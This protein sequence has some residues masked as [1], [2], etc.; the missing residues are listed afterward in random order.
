MMNEVYQCDQ[1]H[2]SFKAY[3][4]LRSHQTV[5]NREETQCDQCG[6][7]FPSSRACVSHQVSFH[8]RMVYVPPTQAAQELP[9]QVAQEP[10]AHR[11]EWPQVFSRCCPYCELVFSSNE[12]CDQ[13]IYN[14]H[15]EEWRLRHSN[16]D[17]NNFSDDI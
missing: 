10:P 3:S 17:L 8:K 2:R 12:E 15:K 13:H 1:C 14:V 5:H 6:Q 16:F 9:V 4:H 7:V 11:E